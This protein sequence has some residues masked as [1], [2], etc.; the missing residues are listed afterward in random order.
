MRRGNPSRPPFPFILVFWTERALEEI[1][2]K[3]SSISLSPEGTI[4]LLHSPKIRHK[5][6]LTLPELEILP[7]TPFLLFSFKSHRIIAAY[8]HFFNKILHKNMLEINWPA[9]KP[10]VHPCRKTQTTLLVRSHG[11]FECK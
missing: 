2:K 7:G 3:K 8:S 4:I 10:I 5:L 9:S 11:H 6:K 1:N